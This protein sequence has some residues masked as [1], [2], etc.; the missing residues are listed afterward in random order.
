MGTR[1]LTM[2]IREGKPVV[3]QYGQWDGY[4]G[5]QG[6]TILKFLREADLDLFKE[7]L[8]KV[9]FMTEEESK[10][11]DE[12]MKSIGSTDG[13][14]NDEQAAKYHA[15][16]PFLSRDHGGEILPMIYGYEG[17][18]I[19]LTDS[20]TFAAD[21]LFCEWA[22][23]VDLDKGT[24][25]IYSGFRTQ[26]LAEGERFKS[27]EEKVEPKK[28]GDTYYPVGLVKSYTLAELPTEDQFLEDCEEKEEEEETEE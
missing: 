15:K 16:Y 4:P 20:S 12:F 9:H 27:L 11:M 17:E 1:N 25:E 5:G 2:V 3:A 19:M 24:F 10:E 14:M 28:S 7:K 8:N 26:P 21:S 22:Y 18:S 23:V 13:W 6:S